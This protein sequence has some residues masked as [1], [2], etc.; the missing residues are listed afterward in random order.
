MV[1]R[2]GL[3]SDPSK[4]PN[5]I[6]ALP[7]LPVP[8]LLPPL[9]RPCGPPHV[10]VLPHPKVPA[11]AALDD[12]NQ[13]VSADGYPV[14]AHQPRSFLETF[15]SDFRDDSH[16]VLY[17]VETEE[18]PTTGPFPRIAKA[19]VAALDQLR[20]QDPGG[21]G[22]IKRVSGSILA[23]DFDLPQHTRWT[24]QHR[25]SVEAL[26]TSATRSW[27]LLATPTVF[28]ATSGGF[29]LVWALEEPVDVR[30]A[31][32][33]EDLLAGLVAQ[34][35]IAGL[36]VDPACK[37]WTRLFRLPRVT[38][39]DKP[40]VEAVTWLQSYYA[41][42]WGRI[43]F[44]ARESSPPAGAPQQHPLSAF[45]GLSELAPRDFQA[46]P[47]ARA[48]S[49]RKGWAERIGRPPLDSSAAF[50]LVDVGHCPDDA[51]VQQAITGG[52]TESAAWKFAVNTLK[53]MA[54][55]K[56]A[57]KTVREAV[58][59]YKVVEEHADIRDAGDGTKE[60]HTGISRL[61][62]A[63]CFCFRENLGTDITEIS[64]Q[65]IY[66]MVLQPA[67]IGNKAH[68]RD[69]NKERSETELAAEV[70]RLVSW[71]YQHFRGARII[72][73]EEQ[74]ER[75]VDQQTFQLQIL[76]QIQAHQETVINAFVEWAETKSP[77]I[78]E[79]ARNNWSKMLLMAY[80]TDRYLLKFNPDGG[81][82]YSETPTSNWSNMLS[83]GRDCG[84][85]FITWDVTTDKGTRQAEEKEIVPLYSTMAHGCNLSRLIPRSRVKLIMAG[86][87][88]VPVLV[89][90]LPGMRTD[91]VPKHNPLVEEWLACLGGPDID[92][93]LDWL[94]AFPH[95]DRPCPAL[96]LQGETGIGK[97]LLSKALANMCQSRQSATIDQ[98]FGRFQK[99]MFATPFILCDERMMT[100]TPDRH[101][102]DTFKKLITGEFDE[103]ERKGIDQRKVEGQWRVL[104]TANH[105]KAIPWD[106]E[107]SGAD[108]DALVNRIIHI[109]ADSRATM[110]FLDRVGQRQGTDGWDRNEVPGHLAWLAQERAVD[111]TSRFL[112]KSTRKDYHESISTLTA[113][114]D[115]VI[116]L[117][118]RMLRDIQRYPD[119]LFVHEGE[120]CVSPS[121]LETELHKIKKAL[122]RDDMPLPKTL[123]S[124]GQT[125][126]HL[127]VDSESILV[128]RKETKSKYV[129]RVRVWR[130]NMRLII[131]RLDGNGDDADLRQ[132]MGN[133]MWE[134]H[135]PERV[136]RMYDDVAVNTPPPPPPPPPPPAQ[137]TGAKVI[138]FPRTAKAK[139]E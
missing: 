104:I 103:L 100:K 68:G 49:E 134:K 38:R 17:T 71:H 5:V 127:S 11:F 99:A 110:A 25:A 69:G 125:I 13:M 54:Y 21:L 53:S 82:S 44:W 95:I 136:R 78:M 62:R 51:Q 115:S 47:Q 133:E 85:S 132:V 102:M 116:S 29:R 4:N 15:G 35:Y 26:L 64:P 3:R 119:I 19:A 2:P 33:L 121:K 6:P 7:A 84:H 52:G 18:G 113:T 83:L 14:Q 137:N 75:E 92:S 50:R 72:R 42:S 70:W 65:F 58:L 10:L 87:N 57:K 32:G 1:F 40:P 55:P 67:R 23:L 91:I 30:G 24:E 126:K 107:I 39:A 131:E 61:A 122:A 88:V 96:Y 138:L 46:N 129:S 76:E 118:G 31:R 117:L 108:L 74:A 111:R 120:M 79:Y 90:A 9:P 128:N 98:A 20:Q 36:V 56:D 97:G 28:Y 66:A 22:R 101:I 12:K 106:N 135:A 48:L 80:G 16:M 124:L 114:T 8:P 89:E 60:L 105:D 63:L 37:D 27:P 109:K 73:M 94:A 112:V 86:S 43:D 130:L 93:L 34:A 77:A 81:V 45:R 139:V 59:A 123:K 41:Q